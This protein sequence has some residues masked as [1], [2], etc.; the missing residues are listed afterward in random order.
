MIL[1]KLL[2]LAVIIFIIRYVFIK[3]T[4]ILDIKKK[5]L[6]NLNRANRLLKHKNIL[7]IVY[8]IEGYYYYNQEAFIEMIDNI[9]A[10][11]EIIE[12]IRVDNHYSTKLY[13]NLN[14]IKKEILNNI[15]SFELLLPKEYNVSVVIDDMCNVLDTYLDEVYLLH[16]NYIKNNKMDYTV[17]IYIPKDQDGYNIDYNILEP[18]KRLLF[19]RV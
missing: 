4:E 18:N 3:K 19:N 11:L 16:E 17:K 1:L 15:L 10:F 12:L 7:D 5:K 13:D 14:D 2:T 6:V 8:S 9:E